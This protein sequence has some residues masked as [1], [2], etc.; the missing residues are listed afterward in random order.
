MSPLTYVAVRWCIFPTFLTPPAVVAACIVG[1]I[2][3]CF[4]IVVAPAAARFAPAAAAT[5][6]VVAFGSSYIRAA[7]VAYTYCHAVFIGSR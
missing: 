4:Y 2:F 5:F 6:A 7:I 3:N 1:G